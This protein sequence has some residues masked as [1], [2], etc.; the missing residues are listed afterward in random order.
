MIILV[1]ATGLQLLLDIEVQPIFQDFTPR[2]VRS[3][4][5][6]SAIF[7][8]LLRRLKPIVWQFLNVAER[9][10]QCLIGVDTNSLNISFV[11]VV[12]TSSC[13]IFHYT[14]S[15]TGGLSGHFLYRLS[16]GTSFLAM[17]AVHMTSEVGGN[18]L[19]W[20]LRFDSCVLRTSLC[21][22]NKAL[23]FVINDDL[24]LVAFLLIIMLPESSCRCLRVIAMFKEWAKLQLSNI[25]RCQKRKVSKMKLVS[26]RVDVLFPGEQI[27]FFWTALPSWNRTCSSTSRMSNSS[28]S[29]NVTPIST[30]PCLIVCTIVQLC[31][32]TFPGLTMLFLYITHWSW[33]YTKDGVHVMLLPAKYRKSDMNFSPHAI[34]DRYRVIAGLRVFVETQCKVK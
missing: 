23:R 11:Y 27:L 14:C 18:V 16:Y 28:Y 25:A 8:F 22:I 34:W 21:N 1:F 31:A 13:V 20:R 3:R 33:V 9:P 5:F 29:Y 30:L 4:S 24:E 7:C 12:S 6:F 26:T 15:R 19:K 2:G 17:V 10:S 32:Q